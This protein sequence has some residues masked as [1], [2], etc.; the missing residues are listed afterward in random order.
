M[1]QIKFQIPKTL[2]VRIFYLVIIYLLITGLLVFI[3]NL[4]IPARLINHTIAYLFI[5]LISAIILFIFIYRMSQYL[6]QIETQ[7]FQIQKLESM[8]QLARG[9][10]HDFNNLMLVVTSNLKFVDNIASLD[11]E[12]RSALQSAGKAS[13]RAS[14]LIQRFIALLR[15]SK[16]ELQLITLNP[17]VEEV[18]DL[19]KHSTPDSIQIQARFGL[20][21]WPVLADPSQIIQIL[22]NLGLNAV[23]AMPEGGALT[24]SLQNRIIQDRD[25]Q[26]DPTLKKGSFVEIL[27]HDTGIGMSAETLTHLFEPFYTTKAGKGSGLGL[28]IADQIAKQLGGWVAVKSEEGKGSTFSVFLPGAISSI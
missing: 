22:L 4:L 8:S 27:V 5:I 17:L 19:L 10:G 25:L 23:E 16:I 2:V 14:Q 6:T 21:I 28:Y 7:L 1:M 9:V 12:Q 20:D 11:D 3:S 26:L 15:D 13:F 24:F 18:V